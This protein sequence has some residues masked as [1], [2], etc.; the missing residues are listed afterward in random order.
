MMMHHLG[1]P[2]DFEDSSFNSRAVDPSIDRPNN[3]TF[4]AASISTHATHTV[5]RVPLQ[6]RRL[7]TPLD[8]LESGSSAS[9]E[10][11]QTPSEHL[12]HSLTLLPSWVR[13]S[14]VAHTKFPQ[15]IRL[16]LV[17]SFLSVWAHIFYM[18]G[19][20]SLSA[21][22]TSTVTVIGPFIIYSNIF[23]RICCTGMMSEVVDACSQEDV[24]KVMTIAEAEAKFHV[25]NAGGPLVACGVIYFIFVRPELDE[26]SEDA[27]NWLVIETS[28]LTLTW[29]FLH[30]FYIWGVV[31]LQGTCS[32]LLSVIAKNHVVGVVSVLRNSNLNPKEKLKQLTNDQIAMERLFAS[33]NASLSAPCMAVVIG[34]GFG[35]LSL[36]LEVILSARSGISP[37]SLVASCITAAL[38]AGGS[39]SFLLA[40]ASVHD[41]YDSAL[42]PLKHSLDLINLAEEVFPG[43]GLSYLACLKSEMALGFNI[44]NQPINSRLVVSAISS[45]AGAMLMTIVLDQA[46]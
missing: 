24:K 20:L 16:A 23:Q 22:I 2:L 10:Q 26:R 35:S 12:Q 28:F 30:A 40:M 41:A 36:G 13:M 33:A 4:S 45:F 19:F 1:T 29:V 5:Q 46:A 42:A 37:T 27:G 17:V 21:T 44:F 6:P 18:V 8:F 32:R 14:L 11:L 15:V 38:L 31:V 34:I 3:S 39:F 25:A 43:N 9:T 7:G